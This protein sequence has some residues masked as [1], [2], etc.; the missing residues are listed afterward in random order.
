[1]QLREAVGAVGA[2]VHKP[3]PL[4]PGRGRLAPKAHRVAIHRS[5]R[6]IAV[7]VQA[8]TPPE[9][10]APQL[11]DRHVDRGAGHETHVVELDVTAQRSAAQH[12]QKQLRPAQAL[13]NHRYPNGQS[14]PI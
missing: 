1:M 13:R 8:L 11:R 6:Q 4:G 3:E 7:Q 12:R 9:P 2:Q 5:H 10:L 14:L